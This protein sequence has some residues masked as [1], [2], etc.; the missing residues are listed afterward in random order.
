[1]LAPLAEDAAIRLEVAKQQDAPVAPALYVRASRGIMSP[2]APVRV[3]A[4][5]PIGS[6]R[7]RRP[8]DAG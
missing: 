5:A 6:T 4:S 7:G 8:G 1:M 2:A 3:A